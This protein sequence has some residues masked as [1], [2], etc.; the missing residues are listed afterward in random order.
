MYDGG[1]PWIKFVILFIPLV[2][3]FF[4]FAPSFKWTVIFTFGGA[5]AIWMALT[6]KSMKGYTGRGSK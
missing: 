3:F 1:F 6:G 5:F 4:I 2:I